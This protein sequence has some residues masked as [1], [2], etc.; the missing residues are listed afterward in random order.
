MKRNNVYSE[1][2]DVQTA[3]AYDSASTAVKTKQMSNEKSRNFHLSLPC[4]DL[5]ETIEFY[6]KYFRCKLGRQYV[7]WVDINLYG[8]E[9]TFVKSGDFQFQYNN[10]QL[11]KHL[12][13]SFHFGIV[14]P[15]KK[16]NQV[17]EHIMSTDETLFTPTEYLIGNVGHHTSF[18]VEDPNGYMVE[19][20][21]FENNEE[22][23]ESK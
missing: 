10:Y 20:K 11:D 22:I 2:A 23:F 1:D 5:Q 3:M 13:P 6:R 4:L 19:L 14:L 18:F 15:K 7:D 16:W 8:N 17:Y 21:C 9:I 12:L